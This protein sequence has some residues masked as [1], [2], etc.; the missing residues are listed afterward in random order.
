M[1]Q[2]QRQRY[3]C[4]VDQQVHPGA[5]LRTMTE[6]LARASVYEAAYGPM[7]VPAFETKIDGLVVP[8]VRE[9]LADR[10]HAYAS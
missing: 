10:G 3:A 6:H 9:A 4:V 1:L 5:D 7:K 8:P 2:E